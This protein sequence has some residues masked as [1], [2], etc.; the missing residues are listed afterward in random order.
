MVV[1]PP[2]QTRTCVGEHEF[3]VCFCTNEPR[4]G[5]QD[6]LSVC[7]VNFLV[8][9]ILPKSNAGIFRTSNFILPQR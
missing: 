9:V 3:E 7:C 1:R 2:G 5:L 4:D 8:C 6:F